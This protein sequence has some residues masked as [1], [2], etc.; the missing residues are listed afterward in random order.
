MDAPKVVPADWIR[1]WLGML[2]A[3]Q[4]G[5][6]REYDPEAMELAMADLFGNAPQSAFGATDLDILGEFSLN[7][8]D[9]AAEVCRGELGSSDD[10]RRAMSEFE[11]QFRLCHGSSRSSISLREAR[12]GALG[13]VVAALL[14]PLS[15]RLDRLGHA[16]DM[17]ER[18]A[19]G[20]SSLGLAAETRVAL[21]GVPPLLEAMG[22]EA[23]ERVALRARQELSAAALAAVRSLIGHRDG[24]PAGAMAQEQGISPST[25]SRALQKIRDLSAEELEGCPEEVHRAFA[26]SLFRSLGLP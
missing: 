11:Y 25:L 24:A 16:M 5:W 15:K 8:P 19:A 13:K 9:A 18:R 10:F 1:G 14:R 26:E 12:A 23:A 2:D 7:G 20:R 17:R 6:R 4:P 3:R 22:R 21:D